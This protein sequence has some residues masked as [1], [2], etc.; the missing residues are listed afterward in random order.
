V[1]PA[2]KHTWRL[3]SEYLK[4]LIP[5]RRS[6]SQSLVHSP[7]VLIPNPV[8][9]YSNRIRT[10][11]ALEATMPDAFFFEATKG[12]LYNGVVDAPLDTDACTT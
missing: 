4:L 11:I 10:L 3:F 9:Y 7:V 5:P 6:V 1:I 12:V 2:P 8:D